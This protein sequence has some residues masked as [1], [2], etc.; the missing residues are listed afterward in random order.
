[1]YKKKINTKIIIKQISRHLKYFLKFLCTYQ[2]VHVVFLTKN[3]KDNENLLFSKNFDTK[4]QLF[5]F[6]I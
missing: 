4:I 3:F 5:I 1:M 2:T 6:F